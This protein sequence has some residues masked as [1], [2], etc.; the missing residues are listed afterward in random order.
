MKQDTDREPPPIPVI[1]TML[2][3][4]HAIWRGGISSMLENTEFKIVG[5]ASS[6]REA[7]ILAR[8]VSPQM[9]LLD[10][11]MAEGDG[12]YALQALKKEHPHMFVILLTTYDNPTY[13]ARAVAGGASG[14]LLKGIDRERML[15]S[16]RAV[17]NGET[18]SALRD[19]VGSLPGTHETAAGSPNLIRPLSARE[20]EVLRL[21]ATGITNREIAAILHITEGTAKSHVEHIIRKLEVS[22]R[23]QAAVWAARH[24]MISL[25]DAE[26]VLTRNL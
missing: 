16:M 21:L 10:I 18:L 25:A 17:V 8:Q 6:G 14:Y 13:M 20:H 2:V 19:F 23:V 15:Q 9:A 24:G 11:R 22:D 12:L 26:P 3:D 7:L 5:E 4:D 1:S